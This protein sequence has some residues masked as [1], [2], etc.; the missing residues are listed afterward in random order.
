MTTDE[1]LNKYFQEPDDLVN[2]KFREIF[3]NRLIEFATYHVELAEMKIKQELEM[4]DRSYEIRVMIDGLNLT[5]N[6]K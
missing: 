1:F 3:K 6:I 4:E 2:G 5:E